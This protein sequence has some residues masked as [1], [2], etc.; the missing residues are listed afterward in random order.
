VLKRGEEVIRVDARPS[1][2]IALA[3]RTHPN[4]RAAYDLL[5]EGP[6]LPLDPR[7]EMDA[8]QGST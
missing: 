2:A 6:P 8:H 5:R 7:S 4:I 3:V 1:D